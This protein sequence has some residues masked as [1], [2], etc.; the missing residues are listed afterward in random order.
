M[1]PLSMNVLI[2]DGPWRMRLTALPSPRPAADEVLLRALAVGICGSDVHGFTGESGRRQPGM[3]MGHEAVG[4]VVELGTGVDTL[5][6]GDHVAVF[7]IVGCGHCHH[8]TAAQEQRCPDKR[9]LGVNAGQWGAMAEQF[10]F[11]ASGLFKIAPSLDPAIGLLTEPIA[12]A[13]HA[14]SHLS[15]RPDD[16]IAIVGAGTIGIGL[17]IALR[18]HGVKTCFALDR[19][20][21]K[22]DLIADFGATPINIEMENAHAVIRAATRGRGADGV[23]EAVGA[24]ATVRTAYDLCAPGGTVVLI[25]NLAREFTLPLQGVTSNETTIRGSYGF[26]RRDFAAAVDL[27]GD[28]LLP[29]DRLISGS[30][31][32]AETPDIMTRMG[33]GEL[34][35]IKMVIRP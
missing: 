16:V 21:A 26:T 19:I 33:R 1:N 15:L 20:P 12:V 24:S 30:C 10:T 11:P 7:N 2:Y 18:A 22:L 9:V 13:E 29:L 17:A 3:V 27:V 31:S 14:I 32:L 25:G 28:P 23:I 4:E 5:A 6:V 8:C 35:P 34:N